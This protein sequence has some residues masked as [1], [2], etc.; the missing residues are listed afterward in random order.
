MAAFKDNKG[1]LW[2]LNLT[3]T[4]AKRI[5]SLTQFNILSRKED[6]WQRLSDD[7]ILL[8]DVIYA[9]VKPDADAKGITD[10]QFGESLVGDAIV[11]ATKALQETYVLFFPA[12]QRA[13]LQKMMKALD[14]LENQKQQLVA[15]QLDNLTE[16]KIAELIQNAMK[17]GDSLNNAQ[18]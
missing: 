2:E 13:N 7:M 11:E 4:S 6:V 9:M 3:T 5:Q 18:A 1:K 14:S 15:K 8:V 10:E 12:Q 17:S 16:E